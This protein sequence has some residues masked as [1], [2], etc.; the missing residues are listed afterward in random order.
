LP[1]LF[2]GLHIKRVFLQLAIEHM[3]VN[4]SALHLLPNTVESLIIPSQAV[5]DN[6]HEFDFAS[7]LPCLQHLELAPFDQSLDELKVTLP[8]GLLS[9]KASITRSEQSINLP[10]SLTCLRLVLP[11]NRYS[12]PIIEYDDAPLWIHPRHFPN[13]ILKTPQ[14]VTMARTTP[15]APPHDWISSMHQLTDL[16]LSRWLPNFKDLPR[17]LRRLKLV[18]RPPFDG[19]RPNWADLPPTLTYLSITFQINGNAC[20]VTPDN[21]GELPKSLSSLSFRDIASFTPEM[22]ARLPSKLTRLVLS[23]KEW[24]A[25]STS[26]IQVAS[27]AFL[28]PSLRH[29]SWRYLAFGWPLDGLPK[30]ISSLKILSLSVVNKD[31][32]PK[33]LTALQ[34][35]F[36][37][38]FSRLPSSLTS[39][40]LRITTADHTPAYLSKV[41]WP[42]TLTWLR[43]RAVQIDSPAGWPKR[44][45]TLIL[46]R[47]GSKSSECL[48]PGLISS[49]ASSSV[50]S[51]RFNNFK[52]TDVD[53]IALGSSKLELLQ[54]SCHPTW[55]TSIT[56]S[57][58]QHLPRS[59]THLKLPVYRMTCAQLRHLPPGLKSFHMAGM[60]ESPPVEVSPNQAFLSPPPPPPPRKVLN[61]LPATLER[62][63]LGSLNF[64]RELYEA[65][66]SKRIILCSD[67]NAVPNTMVFAKEKESSSLEHL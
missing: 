50:R 64:P 36:V 67:W 35:E 39:C 23:P 51:L 62:L 17:G 2:S 29:L 16:H 26:D 25:Q 33:G 47:L 21:I 56:G 10:T 55:C 40:H 48:M 66:L 8:D 20:K 32:L 58:F 24:P 12:P 52:L 28:P 31:M 42:E 59:I 49:I 27:V 44:L 37:E 22:A 15:A 41:E 11:A 63:G 54:V 65:T 13:D 14:S 4:I 57:C 30:Q 34:S 19:P 7:F 43:L 5:S 45:D 18:E 9:L 46:D 53:M 6:C 38:H 61:Y 60:D 1:P 3:Q